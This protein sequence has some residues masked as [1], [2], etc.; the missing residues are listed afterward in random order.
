MQT[1]AEHVRSPVGPKRAVKF[2]QTSPFQRDLQQRVDRYFQETGLPERDVPRMYL[3]TALILAW[4]AGSYLFLLFFARSGWG[5][6]IG[7]V[8]L[9]LAMAGIGFNIQHD[10]NHGGYSNHRAVN[11][12]LGWMLDVLGGSSYLWRWKHNV[13][14]HTHPNVS[15]LDT[16]VES[17]PFI[18]MAPA[19]RRHKHH[20]LQ[21]LYAWWLY[22]LLA[23]LWHFT[24]DFVDLTTGKM[25]GRTVPRPSGGALWA[26]IAG[27]GV[28]FSWVFLVPALRHPLWQVVLAY[29]IASVVLGFTLSV[30]FQLAHCVGE[31]TFPTVPEGGAA[32][33]CDFAEHQIRTTVDF[34]RGNRLVTW[35]LGGLNY[36]V[37]HHLFPQ[38][39]HLHYPALAAI[40]EDTCRA[41][42]V[43]YRAH[44]R[45]GDALL[46]HAR[47]LKEMG[48]PVAVAP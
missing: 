12:T 11:R 3:K 44:A 42:G 20:R 23:V 16:D 14:H 34:A 40:V 26:L 5:L 46:S 18:R 29:G 43:L 21:H 41:H 6:G 22:G 45:V 36:Q 35:Y 48:R 37:E 10:A 47:W 39:S 32:F 17:E 28:F 15:T 25:K 27:K 30:V 9:G 13:F 2:L 7:A 38:V 4:F 31:A 19:Q 33:E 1:Q 8:S 24:S